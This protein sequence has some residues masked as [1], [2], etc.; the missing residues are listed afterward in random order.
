M[1]IATATTAMEVILAFFVLDVVWTGFCW[2][3][4][5]LL[6]TEDEK[7]RQF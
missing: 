2:M 5:H 4:Y 7:D 6:A 1:L 3:M